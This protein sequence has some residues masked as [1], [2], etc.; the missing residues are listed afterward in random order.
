[1]NVFSLSQT[2]Q[3]TPG[4]PVIS[5]PVLLPVLGDRYV[6]VNNVKKPHWLIRNRV[7]YWIWDRARGVFFDVRQWLFK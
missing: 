6:C 3:Y 7:F 5:L 4:F 1:M 2:P